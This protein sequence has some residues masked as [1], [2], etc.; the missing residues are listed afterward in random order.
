MQL[1]DLDPRDV[2][3]QLTQERRELLA[4]LS[5]LTAEE[6]LLPTA[7]AEWNVKAVVLHLLD[8][9]L[10][11]LSRLRDGDTSGQLEVGDYRTFVD[12]LDAK[13]QRWISGA[14]GLSPRVIIR[15]A[16]VLR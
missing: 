5:E 11:W 7:A 14:R 12:A 10:G 8:D 13:N 4:L 2:R 15:P 16:D 6:W 9:D 3:P 1:R